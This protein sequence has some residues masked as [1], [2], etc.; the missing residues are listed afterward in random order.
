MIKT[1]QQSNTVIGNL[2]TQGQS[3]RQ[4]SM[5]IIK[6]LKTCKEKSLLSRLRKE[7]D[8]LEQRRN[9]I[10]QIAISMKNRKKENSPSIDLLIEICR[11]PIY[12]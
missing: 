9:E 7:L 4:R 2:S 12:S 1:L 5:H 6:S 3:L 11:R 8:S 10:L